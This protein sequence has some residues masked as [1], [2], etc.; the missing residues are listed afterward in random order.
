MLLSSIVFVYRVA[1]TEIN[2]FMTESLSYRNQ[3]I[4]LQGISMDC[5]LYDR[6]LRHKRVKRKY[7]EKNS[8]LLMLNI[9]AYH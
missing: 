8:K 5:F 3:S 4:D 9:L 7:Y 2:S 1:V 6:D